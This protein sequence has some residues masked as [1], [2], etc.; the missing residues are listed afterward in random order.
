MSTSMPS[1]HDETQNN[2]FTTCN[3]FLNNNNGIRK[4]T[5]KSGP[6]FETAVASYASRVL[7]KKSPPESVI[8]S[9]V[10]PYVTSMLRSSLESDA[11]TAILSSSSQ[12]FNGTIVQVESLAEYDSML[13]LLEEHCNMSEEVAKSAL[14][15]IA[16]AVVTGVFD[17][18]E[19]RS[20]SSFG[21]KYRSLSMGAENDYSV[22]RFRSLSMGNHDEISNQLG[23]SAFFNGFLTRDRRSSSM[24]HIGDTSMIE[25]E[26][27]FLSEEN[28][29]NRM[30][31]SCSQNNDDVGINYNL[32][33]EEK[34]AFMS[35]P[36][37]PDR[38]IPG[39]LLGFI[40]D[41]S[42]P[43]PIVLPSLPVAEP[44]K[45]E[46]KSVAESPN[47]TEIEGNPE[48]SSTEQLENDSNQD[49]SSSEPTASAQT[50]A[51]R[52]GNKKK[53][54]IKDMD[55]AASLFTRPRSRSI[56]DVVDKSP[57]LKPMAPPPIPGGNLNS[58]FY[59]N[60][61]DSAVQILMAMNYDICEEAATEAALV[62]NADV[63]VAQHVIDGA[64]AAPPV[65]R[66][67]LNDG[68]Y[69][70]DCQFSHDVDGHTCLF[71]LKGRCGKQGC[72]FM[73][74]FSEKLLEG[75]DL[76]ALTS[77]QFS[78]VP[79]TI[80]TTN[81]VQHNLKAQFSYSATPGNSL[82]SPTN[83]R[84]NESM[85]M[86]YTNG[87]DNSTP[88]LSHSPGFNIVQN[89]GRERSQSVPN[90]SFSFA[91][92]A[93]KGYSEKSSF[94]S[95]NVGVNS[96]QNGLNNKKETKTVRIPQNLWSPFY[97]RSSF[98]FHISDPLERYNEVSASVQRDDVID[99]HFQS[100]KTFPIV[101][102]NILPEKLRNHNEV[103]VV[104]GSGHHVNT[105]S[106]QKSGGVLE[107]AV[108]TWLESNDYAYF[109]GRDK[110]GYGG[111]CLVQGKNR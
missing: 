101:L 5:I 108:I 1:Y 68:C 93:S 77:N 22:G 45:K 40:D 6:A 9:S 83:Y 12:D 54:K 90:P 18:D 19:V 8:D 2:A 25:E 74:G 10:G 62:S 106:H 80:Q 51:S 91:S 103:W 107:K 48:T 44:S 110:N 36:L 41:P 21:G 102:S 53:K 20:L 24:S 86:G 87:Y 96:S 34:E 73:H 75:V 97:N 3:S 58:G 52:A 47:M 14:Q 63:N 39:D 84:G 109:L 64:V 95:N 111:A 61:I 46:E 105:N 38:L 100:V 23:T 57:K 104:C 82:L 60:N 50:N 49:S 32:N 13:E 11:T 88:P 35:T 98:A 94:G 31:E 29:L 76:K 56:H 26:P 79:A 78:N 99:L 42:T 72:K 28:D 67:M 17:D 4:Q 81:L 92:I 15:S 59:N 66:H 43:N 85:S 89:N 7:K 37:K 16:K 27:S 65:C 71:W 55:L 33:T 69:R 30:S 70:S